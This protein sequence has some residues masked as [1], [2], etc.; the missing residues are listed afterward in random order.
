VHTPDDAIKALL[1]GADVVQL[2]SVLLKH[3]PTH[4]S[5]LIAGLETWMAELEYDSVDQLR[6]AMNRSRCPDPSAHERA[7]YLKILQNW[8]V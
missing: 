1:A 5:T 7:N 6:G 2:V 8:K 3:G 4:V